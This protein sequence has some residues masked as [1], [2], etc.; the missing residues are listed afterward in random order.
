MLE[1]ELS[2]RHLPMSFKHLWTPFSV[3]AAV[4]LN[5][6]VHA[7]NVYRRLLM[8]KNGMYPLCVTYSHPNLHRRLVHVQFATM[9]TYRY[10]DWRHTPHNA[11]E[12]N[13]DMWNRSHFKRIL[14]MI[15]KMPSLEWVQLD[16][17][18]QT[19]GHQPS[20]ESASLPRVCHT[21][22]QYLDCIYLKTF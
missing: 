9:Q 4:L 7:R 2:R 3:L 8:T 20:P 11:T 18:I 1:K 17:P 12:K 15:Q 13:K 5:Q 21:Q 14:S 10:I 6:I 16:L 22:N 19:A